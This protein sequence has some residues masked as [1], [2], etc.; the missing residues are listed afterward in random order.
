MFNISF[1]S[2]HGQVIVRALIKQTEFTHSLCKKL[3]Y[4]HR[5]R[6]RADTHVCGTAGSPCAQ[7]SP[8]HCGSRRLLALTSGL[9]CY[10]RAWMANLYTDAKLLFYYCYSSTVTAV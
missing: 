9:L 7:F 1:L 10:K 4:N 5:F 3:I 6:L 8:A 2:F